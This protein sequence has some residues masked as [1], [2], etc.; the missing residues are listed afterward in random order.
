MVDL[1]NELEGRVAIVTGSARNIGR[2]TAME[3]ARAGAALVI[4]ARE[5]IGLC[6]EVAHSIEAN[7]GRAIPVVAD[8]TDAEAVDAMVAEAV[9]AFGGVDILVNNAA[10]RAN[11]PFVDLDDETWQRAFDTSVRGSFNTSR[12]CVPHM[13]QRGGGSVIAV[14]G[15][16]TYKGA[17]GRSHVM[18]AKDGLI[19]LTRGLAVDL[20]PQNIR[21]NTVVVGVFD[22]ERNANAPASSHPP[23]VK[24]PLGRKGVPQDM[25]DLIRFLVGPG[26]AYISGQTIHCNGASHCPH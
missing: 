14:A 15:L 7:G 2:A 4:N 26:A 1:V 9:K 16:S 24:I 11:V 3:L 19:G 17:P 5:S 22:T 6:E 8:I 12:A 10:V 25:A 13:I 20:G 18:A 23:D 21:A